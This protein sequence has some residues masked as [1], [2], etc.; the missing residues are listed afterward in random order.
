MTMLENGVYAPSRKKEQRGKKK[1]GLH[2]LDK[3]KN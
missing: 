2:F 3:V 1:A